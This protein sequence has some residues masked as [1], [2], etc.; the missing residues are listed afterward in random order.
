MKKVSVDK[1]R[2]ELLLGYSMPDEIALA[3]EMYDITLDG[4]PEEDMQKLED[5]DG[6]GHIC[7]DILSLQSQLNAQSY[8]EQE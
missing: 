7:Y 5:V 2:L 1:N 4:T 6:A 8:D 3:E